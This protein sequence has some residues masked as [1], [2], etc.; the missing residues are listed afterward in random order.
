MPLISVRLDPDDARKAAELREAGIAISS[1]VREA[2]RREHARETARERAAQDASQIV[3][4]ILASL[5]DKGEPRRRPI[6]PT[7]RRAV[8]RHIRTKLRARRT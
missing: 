2:I 4:A 5:P 6:D 3:E 8:A 7:D 1:V